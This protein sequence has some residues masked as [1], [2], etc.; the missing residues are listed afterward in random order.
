MKFTIFFNSISFDQF[1]VKGN[2]EMI[3]PLLEHKDININAENNIH[4]IYIY[5]NQVK[6]K[7]K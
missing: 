6:K 7:I 5:S 1:N 2:V 4:F 3:K